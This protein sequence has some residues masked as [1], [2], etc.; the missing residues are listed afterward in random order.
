[1]QFM[2]VDRHLLSSSAFLSQPQPGFGEHCL[3]T[4]M[5]LFMSHGDGVKLGSVGDG[6]ADGLQSASSVHADVVV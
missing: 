5:A 4:T 1:M 3:Q 2:F 6:T